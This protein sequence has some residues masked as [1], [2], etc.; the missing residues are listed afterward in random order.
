[1]NKNDIIDLNIGYKLDWVLKD[2]SE[3]I[4]G[5]IVDMR[6]TDLP[7]RSHKQTAKSIY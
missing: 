4:T 5:E 7:W 1:M 2:K 6:N 3:I